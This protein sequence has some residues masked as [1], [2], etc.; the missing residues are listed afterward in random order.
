[1]PFPKDTYYKPNN[2]VKE[3]WS[4]VPQVGKCEVQGVKTRPYNSYTS[5]MIPFFYILMILAIAFDIYIGV[6]ILSKQGVNLGLIVGSVIM[7]I[8][9][10]VLPFL[11]EGVFMKNL[12]HTMIENSIFVKILESKCRRLTDSD[13]DVTER[14][15]RIVRQLSELDSDKRKSNIYRFV[16]A[17]IIFA[18][19]AWKIYTFNSV[20]PPS[21][22]IWAVVKGKIIIIFS[23]L[24]AIFH[25]IGTEKAIAHLFFYR[26]AKSDYKNYMRVG[27]TSNAKPSRIEL[28]YEGRF[29]EVEKDREHKMWILKEGEKYYIEFTDFIRDEEIMRLSGS[30]TDDTAERVVAFKCKENQL[31]I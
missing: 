17:F 2:S 20:L 26:A 29:E 31:S 19:A 6:F 30:Q 3:L 11:I 22:S 15:E 12:N 14:K 4:L 8:F 28:N 18:I 27:S 7:D 24:T 13:K 5:P 23:L 21:F 16:I 10:G 9:L 1:M 25:L